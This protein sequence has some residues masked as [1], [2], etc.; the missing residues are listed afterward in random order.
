MTDWIEIYLLARAYELKYVAC[1]DLAEHVPCR[2]LGRPYDLKKID[3]DAKERAREASK[4]PLSAE[5]PG[6]FLAIHSLWWQAENSESLYDEYKLKL[7]CDKRNAS[8]FLERTMS[9]NSVL[10]SMVDKKEAVLYLAE[11]YGYDRIKTEVNGL[12]QA[13]V[14]SVLAAAP[15]SQT[16]T[17]AVSILTEPVSISSAGQGGIFVPRKLWEGRIYPAIRDA[18]RPKDEYEGYPDFVIAYVLFN[19]CGLKN[20][21]EI[22]R[23]LRGNKTEHNDSTF[24]RSANSLLKKAAHHTISHD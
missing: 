5:I 12:D 11:H 10:S 14:D 2:Y 18:M 9:F 15:S 16:A 22:G 19:W 13:Y 8:E 3:D 4:N 6:T 24:L 17:P 23:L 1:F 21:T 20:K 7:R